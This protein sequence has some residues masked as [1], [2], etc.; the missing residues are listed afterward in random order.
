MRIDLLILLAALGFCFGTMAVYGIRRDRS[1]PDPLESSQ[2]GTFVLGSFIRTWFFWFIG[3]AVRLALKA[4]LSPLFFNL[5]GAGFGALAGVAFALGHPVLGG[6]LVF[7]GGSADVFDGRV[8]RSLGISLSQ[9][10]LAWVLS[11]TLVSSAIIGATSDEHVKENLGA[12]D[13]KLRSET[14]AAIERII[15]NNPGE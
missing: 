4:G 5:T 8:A 12:V 9:L 13:V 1:Q 10:A 11:H 6:W 14:L 7:A 2:R 15:A 3:P